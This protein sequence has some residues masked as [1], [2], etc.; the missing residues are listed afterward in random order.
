MIGKGFAKKALLSGGCQHTNLG[1]ENVV[2][3]VDSGRKRGGVSAVLAATALGL[4]L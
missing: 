3:L 4:C 2:K 1:C